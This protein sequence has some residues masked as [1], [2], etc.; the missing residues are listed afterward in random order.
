FKYPPVVFEK[1][2][3]LFA[4]PLPW[5]MLGMAVALAVVAAWSYL[6][7]RRS[8]QPV[9]RGILLA[10]R[11]GMLA[12]LLTALFRPVMQIAVAVPQENYLGILIDDSRSMRIADSGNGSRGELVQSGL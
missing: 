6:R 9:D 4:S 10:L 8:L 1:G 2:R 11:G 3:L 12:I 5:W 7:A